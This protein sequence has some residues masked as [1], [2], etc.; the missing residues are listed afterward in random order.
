G[1]A[2]LLDF[3]VMDAS[4]A[5]N[6]HYD[7]V[8][9]VEGISGSV[10]LKV[11]VCPRFDYGEIIPLTRC[12]QEGV[13][14]AIG[15]NKGLVIRADFPLDVIEHR[16]LS[17]KLTVGPGERHRLSIYFESP[18][19]IVS[20][21]FRDTRPMDADNC[22]RSTSE[23]WRKWSGRIRLPD[24]PDP[25]TIRSAIVLRALAYER[26][27]AIIAASTTSLPEDMG[28]SR[29]WDYRFTWVR[30]SVFTIRALYELGYEREAD[31]FMQFIRRASAGS[32]AQLQIMYGVDGKR[33]LT[34]VE[35]EW[36]E[37]YCKSRPVRVGNAAARQN[38]L[39]VYGEILEIAHLWNGGGDQSHR[40]IDEQYRAFLID[41]VDTVCHRW[42]DQDYGI[43]E[44]RG[45]PRHYVHSK[46]MCW[47][48]LENGIHLA[49][50]NHFDAPLDHWR[51]ER[52]ALRHAI[53]S[54]GYDDKRGVF[55]QSFGSE[56]LD[57]ALLLLPRT[58]FLDYD[59][60]R[61]VRTVD[62]IRKELDRDGLLARYNAPDGLK[63]KE[64][65]FLPC[66]FWLVSCLA[67]QGRH[68]PAWKHYR[69]ALQ[70]AN[71]IGLFSEE[72]DTAH[73]RMLGNFPQALTHVSQITARLALANRRQAAAPATK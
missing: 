9:I 1:E 55:V 12:N 28:G 42:K 33:R 59:D 11:E 10:E 20:P 16:D 8:R 3:F 69:R 50:D 18:E 4:S 15:S 32:A 58:G 34:E 52:D 49:E 24:D 31:R 14:T 37:G 48:A 60:P 22:L 53:E 21:D 62:A 2:R 65:V 44:F 67:M 51:K 45:G 70:C 73:N 27:G 13:Y 41:V 66:T 57:A 26:T 29:N 43:W 54:E 30:D 19:I 56:Y 36:L 39:D 63:G 5:E 23:W 72:Y 6:A 68:D 17:A 61:M 71:D 7:H 35:L 25:E 47:S 64:G 38:Q 40:G 46:A